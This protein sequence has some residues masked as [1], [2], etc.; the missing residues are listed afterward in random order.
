MYKMAMRLNESTCGRRG[1]ADKL[2]VP[3]HPGEECMNGQRP[4]VNVEK[5]GNSSQV[6]LEEMSLQAVEED[7]HV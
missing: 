3:N 1:L 6:K 5:P 4:D 7:W 2:D